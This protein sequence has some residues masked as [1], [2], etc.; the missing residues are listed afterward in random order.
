M[1][2]SLVQKPAFI[3]GVFALLLVVVIGF[4]LASRSDSEENGDGDR[5]PGN[6]DR[7]Y[8][9]API[10]SLEIVVLDSSPPVYVAEIV[11][12][13][14]NG[15]YER[16]DHRVERDG[17]TFVITVRNTVPRDLSAISC[18]AIYGTYNLTVE[19]GSDLE[20]GETYTVD[21]NG[22]TT[23]FDVA[24]D[25]PATVTPGGDTPVSSDDPPAAPATPLPAGRMLADAPIESVDVVVMESFPPQYG[26]HI[27]AGLPSGCAEKAGYDVSRAG[28]RIEV[29]VHNSVPSDPNV[30]CTMIYGIYDLNVNLGSDFVPG[31]TYTVDVN[32]TEVTFTA[33]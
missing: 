14:P 1:I 8:E 4:A 16:G 20:V 5:P 28:N 7:V 27:V 17:N 23:S 18:A 3:A 19:L 6:G 32:G 15:C 24:D 31:R 30:V 22:T 2:Q 13:L 12:G 26:L 9:P 21:V 10:E 29:S 11:A 33:Q 25:L